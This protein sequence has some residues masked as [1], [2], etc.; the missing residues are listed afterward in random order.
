[1]KGNPVI[2]VLQCMYWDIHSMIQ[3]SIHY[4]ITAMIQLGKN[5]KQA[6]IRETY[7]QD[8]QLD[9]VRG[10]VAMVFSH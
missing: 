7:L 2:L 10:G 6:P 9:G 8:I 3:R 5:L 1:M 4:W